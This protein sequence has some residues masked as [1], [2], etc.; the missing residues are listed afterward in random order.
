MGFSSVGIG[1]GVYRAAIARVARPFI[2]SKSQAWRLRLGNVL[3]RARHKKAPD[4]AGAFELLDVSR[5]Q[6]F[7]TKGPPQLKR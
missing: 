2:R 3:I 5:D 1:R 6:Y 4:D 7:A